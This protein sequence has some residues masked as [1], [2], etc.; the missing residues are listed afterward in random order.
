MTPQHRTRHHAAGSG[1]QVY[2]R[3]LAG[4]EDGDIWG[5]IARKGGGFTENKEGW[6]KVIPV[7][8]S[9]IIVLLY[10]QRQ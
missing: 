2:W 3:S 9:A 8:R 10:K 7:L 6:N 5:R 4:D 1:G